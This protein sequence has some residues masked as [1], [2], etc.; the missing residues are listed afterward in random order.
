MDH[1]IGLTIESLVAVLLAVTISYCFVLNK[2]LKR[3]RADEMTLKATISELITATDI[4][5][6]AIAGLKATVR[7]C[8]EGLTQ[9]LNAASDISARL[10]QQSADTHDLMRHL[11]RILTAGRPLEASLAP[12]SGHAAS[13]PA[14][15]GAPRADLK[16]RSAS[17]VRSVAAAAGAFAERAQSRIDGLA[18]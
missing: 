14:K 13:A 18:A 9:R 2:R 4:A 6:R 1:L 10:D 11:T 7:D 3:L 17:H 15:P 5:E 12:Q 16:E 8:D